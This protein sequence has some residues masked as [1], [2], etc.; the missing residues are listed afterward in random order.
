[1]NLVSWYQNKILI[2][3]ITKN[4]LKTIKKQKKKDKPNDKSQKTKDLQKKIL[5]QKRKYF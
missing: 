2:E 4:K 3:E 5:G 1:M